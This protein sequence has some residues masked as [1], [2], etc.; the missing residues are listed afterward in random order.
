LTDLILLSPLKGWAAAL[1]EAPDPVFAERMMGDG[2]LIDPLGSTLHAPCDARVISVHHTR[3]AVT[4]RA[5]NGAEILMHV[6]LET[7]A[8]GGEGFEPHVSDGQMVKAG[9][10]LLSFDLDVLARRARSLVTPIIL[11]NSDNFQVVR[12]TEGRAVEVGDVLMVLRPLG[13]SA[14]SV[15]T[16]AA[17][18]IQ[19]TVRPTL[20]HGLHARPAATV[21]SCAKRFSAEVSVGCDGRKANAKS[22]VAL[23]A[24]GVRDGDEL[25]VTAS[26][27]DAEAAVV[28]VAQVLA[29]LRERPDP[30]P[31][32]TT[33][34]KTA[35]AA[36]DDPKLITGVSAAPGLAVG[37]ALRFVAPEIVID[38]A[39]RGATLESAELARARGAVRDSL[40]RSALGGDK[41][42][43][44]IL[45]AHIALLDDPELVAV[46]QGLIDRDK[47]AAFGWRQAIRA[48]V[49]MLEGLADRRMVERVG[50]LKDLERQVLIALLGQDGE[51]APELPQGAILLADELLP[52][53]LVGLDATRLAGFCT[54]GGGPTSHVA[55][56]AAAMGLPAVVAAGAGVLTIADGTPLILDA[57]KGQLHLDPEPWELEGVQTAL[58]ARRRRKTAARAVAREL[59]ATADGTRI[60][61]FANLGK[62]SEAKAAVEAGAEGCGLL[63]TEFLFLERAS[64]PDE[65]EQHAAYQAIADGLQGRPLIV[66]TLDIGGDKPAPYL[67]IPYEDNPALGLRGVRTSLWRPDLL[68]TQLRAI[69]RVQPAGVCRIMV[70]MVASVGELTAVRAI[71]DEVITELEH[72]TP[73]E[74]GVMV[75][76]PAC[77]VLADQIAEVA[78]FLSVGTNDLTQYALAMDRGNPALA[79]QLDALHPAVL[80]LIGLAV[81]G[82]GQ[83]G[84]W[85]GVCGGLASDPIAAPILVG[86]GVT[87][88]SAT[89]TAIPEIKAAVRA[90]SMDQ[91]REVTARAL[92]LKSAAEVRALLLETWPGSEG[93]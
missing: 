67:P 14:A 2:V 9:D 46:A 23:M 50:D 70:P 29:D 51:P 24:L 57:D 49:A 1:D 45:A 42:R 75:E 61:V 43:R 4:L 16:A 39:G 78:D 32:S 83:H 59:C 28:A 56:L 86:L 76:T 63:R 72:K 81:E 90:V 6:G 77:A 88:L 25:S 35:V 37:H 27:S 7:V 40:E 8:L 68:R 31:A 79:A 38:E 69:L 47:S 34:L 5:E 33:P 10:P 41:E 48:Q 84:R 80:R 92:D 13:E 87:E 91:C 22:V 66:R 89:P 54:S 30:H 65:D 12:R 71:L 73:V 44:S 17:A 3:H 53:Q 82:A 60:E 26:G 64:P 11:A 15:D 85:V 52:S 18:D 93:A 36:S 20:P 74:L 19:R 55:I 58:E 62:P 21:A